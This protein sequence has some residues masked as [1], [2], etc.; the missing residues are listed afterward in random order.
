MAGE[1]EGSNSCARV[2]VSHP[3]SVRI[4]LSPFTARM[5]L[6]LL[7]LPRIHQLLTICLPFPLMY[8]CSRL[9]LPP[10]S[11]DLQAAARVSEE[12]QCAQSE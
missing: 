2:L 8:R 6:Q 12:T 11:R 7:L 5:L 1:I 3:L 9:S 10:S 4:T